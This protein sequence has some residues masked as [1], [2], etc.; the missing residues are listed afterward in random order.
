MYV[1][2]IEIALINLGLGNKDNFF[3]WMEKAYEE[4]D[5]FMPF[6]DAIFKDR[7][8]LSTDPRYRTLLKKINLPV[9]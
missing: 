9:D 6:F 2:S 4:H 7:N 1:S 3:E 5:P 8:N